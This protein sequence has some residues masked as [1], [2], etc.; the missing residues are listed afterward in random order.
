MCVREGGRK[1]KTLRPATGVFWEYFFHDFSAFTLSVQ[2]WLNV[3]TRAA[4]LP[5]ADVQKGVD[6][7]FII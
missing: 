2:I 7:A 1:A 5:F 6:F 4:L 3:Y